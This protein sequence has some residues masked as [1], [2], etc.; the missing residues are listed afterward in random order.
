MWPISNPNCYRAVNIESAEINLYRLGSPKKLELGTILYPRWLRVKSVGVGWTD[1][2]IDL[3]SYRG[4]ALSHTCRD[5]GVIRTRFPLL[6]IRI[7]EFE[8]FVA[9]VLFGVDGSD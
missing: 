8:K 1:A 2:G 7:R 3:L 6:N 4:H 5:T 9:A